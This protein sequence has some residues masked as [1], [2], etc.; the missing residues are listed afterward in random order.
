MN[1]LQDISSLKE[2]VDPVRCA[3]DLIGDIILD[4]IL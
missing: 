1:L 3:Y 4:F 2:I